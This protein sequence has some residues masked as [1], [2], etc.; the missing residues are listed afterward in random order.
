MLLNL[1]AYGKGFFRSKIPIFA[2][3]IELYKTV[4]ATLD[5]PRRLSLGRAGP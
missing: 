4:R 1:F 2:P 3:V 5:V